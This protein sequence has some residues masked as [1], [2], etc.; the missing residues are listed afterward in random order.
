[1]RL[2]RGVVALGLVSLFMDLSSEMIHA[3]LPLFLTVAL[4]A[5]VAT[6]G[7][8]EGVAE[9]TASFAKVFAGAAS[10]WLGRRKPFALMGYG[11][12]ALAKPLFPLATGAGTVLLARFVDRLGK[13]LRGAPRDA[14]VADLTPAAQRGAAY[15]LRQALDTVGAVLGPLSALALLAATGDAFRLLFW[16]AVA[17]AVASVLVLWRGVHEPPRARPAEERQPIRRAAL[18][19]LP[20]R[21]WGVVA[22]GAVLTLARFSEAFLV[23]RAADAGLA[24]HLAPLALV[25]MNLAFAATSYP[26]GRRSDA[27]RRP[28]ALLG[29]ACLIAADALLVVAAAPGAVLAGAALWGVHMGATQGLL[30]ALVADTTP[31]AIRGTA[32]GVFHCVTG[33]AQLAASVVAGALWQAAGPAAAFACGAAFAALALAGLLVTRPRRT[34]P[35]P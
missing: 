2:P 27:G 8:I 5:S 15:G 30:A 23:L 4:G 6:L 9:A 3:A 25:A 18:A 31:D 33:V 16:V 19:R 34:R 28:V 12:A 11:L 24:L 17:P 32:F 10:D 21:Y 20:R 7:W 13:G 1:M 22:F 35:L 26:L 14:L 29:V